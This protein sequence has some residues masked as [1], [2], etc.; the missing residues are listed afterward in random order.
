LD[1]LNLSRNIIRAVSPTDFHNVQNLSILNLS[2]NQ[3][4]DTAFI[5]RL[6]MLEV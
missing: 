5:N 4:T 6:P 3:I 2:W 1:E